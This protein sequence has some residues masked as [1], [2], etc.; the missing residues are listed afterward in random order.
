[1]W[2]I[3]LSLTEPYLTSVGAVVAHDFV[4]SIQQEPADAMQS[5]VASCPKIKGLLRDAR[6][7]TEGQ[8]GTFRVRKD[9]SYTTERFSIPG[10]FLVGDAACFI[11]PVL[12]TGVHLA[13]YSALLAARS[14]NSVLRG[15]LEEEPA[16]REF[17]RRYRAEFEVFYKYLIAFYDMHK[18]Q[19]SYFWEARKVLNTA[20]NANEAFVRLV[21][22][23]ATDPGVYLQLRAGAGD[24][25]QTFANHLGLEVSTADRQRVTREMASQLLAD[26][27]GPPAAARQPGLED[28]RTAWHEGAATDG[29][30][31]EELEPSVD[32]LHWI[33]RRSAAAE[34]TH[35][36]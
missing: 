25:L 12:S 18:E 20:E 34:E 28:L 22:G 14:V 9:W 29:R 21:S 30:S 13:T 5:F 1:M 4:H 10:M 16:F 24:R 35:P 6:R 36:T 26:A 11:D 31:T 19:N 32:G 15:D 17:E 23:G 3:P 27:S 8:Y 7:V 2:Y 33:A